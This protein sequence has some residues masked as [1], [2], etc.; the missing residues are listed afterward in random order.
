MKTTSMF[1]IHHGRC[2]FVLHIRFIIPLS[3]LKQHGTY[4]Q[5]W[6]RK[7]WKA[8]VTKSTGSSLTYQPDFIELTIF[9]TTKK[10]NF[11]TTKNDNFKQNV[12]IYL[13]LIFAL[14]MCK[15]IGT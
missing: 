10:K 15:T 7:R 14:N 3:V 5:G 1:P 13:K 9:D 12:T 2:I 6:N 4:W 8:T 11:N